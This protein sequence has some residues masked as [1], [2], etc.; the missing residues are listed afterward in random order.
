MPETALAVITFGCALAAGKMADQ[1]WACRSCFIGVTNLALI[2]AEG[3]ALI[4]IC[5][6]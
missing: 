4:Q 1:S 6:Q 3:D 5:P 2:V